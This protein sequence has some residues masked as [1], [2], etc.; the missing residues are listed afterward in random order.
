[1]VSACKCEDREKLQKRQ[2]TYPG[3]IKQLF[4]DKKKARCRI[5]DNLVSASLN[6]FPQ[7]GKH[8]KR[9]WI[10]VRRKAERYPL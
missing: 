2:I 5:I 9:R 4:V 10:H 1:M 7:M 8:H 3:V 6:S